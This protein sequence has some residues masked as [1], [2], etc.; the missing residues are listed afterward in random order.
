MKHSSST[1]DHR[2]MNHLL[3]NRRQGENPFLIK[4]TK[5]M[6][7]LINRRPRTM[8]TSSSTEDQGENHLLINRRTKEMNHLLIN[9]RP[10]R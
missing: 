6:K 1:E 9:R 10:R 2:R 3:I 8:N 7:P 5:E 4:E